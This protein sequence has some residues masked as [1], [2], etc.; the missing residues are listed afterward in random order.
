LATQPKFSKSK[1]EALLE[2]RKNNQNKAVKNI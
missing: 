1:V 2:S